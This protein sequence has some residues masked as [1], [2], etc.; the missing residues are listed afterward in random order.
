MNKVLMKAAAIGAAILFCAQAQ[1][2]EPKFSSCS[3]KTE[4]TNTSLVVIGASETRGTIACTGTNGKQYA[5]DIVVPMFG[6][7]IGVGHCSMELDL[8]FVS[9]DLGI[10]LTRRNVHQL[11]ALADVGPVIPG[12]RS[13][14]VTV[15][16]DIE[17]VGVSAGIGNVTYGK[18]CVQFASLRFGRMWDADSYDQMQADKKAKQQQQNEQR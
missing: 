7:N 15:Q 16:A 11:I 6:L 18:G 17:N 12:K 14:A 9:A 3:L 5:S 1:A 4:G 8:S 10:D 2:I 13:L